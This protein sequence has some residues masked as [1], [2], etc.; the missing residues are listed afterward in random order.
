LFTGLADGPEAAPLIANLT[1][2]AALVWRGR[3]PPGAQLAIRVQGDRAIALL[4]GADVS[5]RLVGLTG[6]VPG[7]AWSPTQVATP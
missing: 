2:G 4:D 5:D 7:E 6:F 3:I 1:T